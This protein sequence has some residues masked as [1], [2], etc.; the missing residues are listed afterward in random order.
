MR[1]TISLPTLPSQAIGINIYLHE[2]LLSM[3]LN[4]Q[5]IRYYDFRLV[6]IKSN[7]AL[8]AANVHKPVMFSSKQK[9]TSKMI[10]KNIHMIVMNSRIFFTIIVCIKNVGGANGERW[11]ASQLHQALALLRIVL[12]S[13]Y[14]PNQ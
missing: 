7:N 1:K 9:N 14:E 12:I 5:Y 11:C 10:E 13:A 2:K 3:K 4:K 8:I 6:G